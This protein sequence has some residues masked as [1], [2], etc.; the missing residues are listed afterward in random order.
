MNIKQRREALGLKE[1]Q[2]ARL[3]KLMANKWQ[4][5]GRID[6]NEKLGVTRQSIHFWETGVYK[7]SKQSLKLLDAVFKTY[8]STGQ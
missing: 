5:E 3:L 6:P 8:E 4:K 2:L 1:H 7:P